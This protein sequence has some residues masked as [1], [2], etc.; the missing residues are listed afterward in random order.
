MHWTL[1]LALLLGPLVLIGVLFLSLHVMIR[2]TGTPGHAPDWQVRCTS[3]D[4]VR[5]AG[6]AG[7]I[8]IAAA[9]AGRRL[10]GYCR[11][12]RGLRWL[13]VE[14]AR[15]TTEHATLMD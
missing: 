11:Q 9:S 8:R 7:V 6:E 14:H 10:F 4:R 3:C 5:E 15:E 13:V 1:Q 2:V 12:R